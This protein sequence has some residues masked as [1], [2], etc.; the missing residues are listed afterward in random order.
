MTL[1]DKLR[2]LRGKALLARDELAARS[3]VALHNIRN[4]EQGCRQPTWRALL[5]LAEA[6]GVDPYDFVAC[7]AKAPSRRPRGRPRN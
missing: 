3:G 4:Y 2:E 7:D 1:A 6:L 5:A